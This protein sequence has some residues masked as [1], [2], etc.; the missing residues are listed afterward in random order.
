MIWRGV[1]ITY[2]AIRLTTN[3]EGEQIE[4]TIKISIGHL[5]QEWI[6][7][8]KTISQFE[9]EGANNKEFTSIHKSFISCSNI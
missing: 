4:D 2:D 9:M 1:Q 8:V 7:Y 6:A 3:T 5:N